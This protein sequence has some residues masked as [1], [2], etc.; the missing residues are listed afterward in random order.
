MV[1]KEDFLL[2]ILIKQVVFQKKIDIEIVKNISKEN[3]DSS[4][5]FIK[6]IFH[7]QKL[8]KENNLK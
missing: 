5:Y 1:I 7:K 8:L 6:R 2:V 3:N 4:D